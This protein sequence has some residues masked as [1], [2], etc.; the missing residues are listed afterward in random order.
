MLTWLSPSEGFAAR[1]RNILRQQGCLKHA[2]SALM[3]SCI[4]LTI[5]MAYIVNDNPVFGDAI[6]SLAVT[7]HA[8]I[9]QM[10]HDNDANRRALMPY[11]PKVR[12]AR[13]KP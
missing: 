12:P 3:T 9:Q 5:P 10:C 2:M 4:D 11:L 1:W 7:C 8:F 6:A 13:Y